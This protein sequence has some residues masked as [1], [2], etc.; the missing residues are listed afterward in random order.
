MESGGC[1]RQP[2]LGKRMGRTPGCHSDPHTRAVPGTTVAREPTHASAEAQR[3]LVKTDNRGMRSTSR[4]ALADHKE[5]GKLGKQQQAVFSVLTLT[6]M[7]FTRAELAKHMGLPCSSICGRV[8]ELLDL[9]VIV[10]D[11]RRPCAVTG[12][13]AHAVRA[14]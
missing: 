8:K 7:A 10:E 5:T 4:D 14:A 3:P 12:K 6:G 11:S 2:D 13:S 1:G 9:Q